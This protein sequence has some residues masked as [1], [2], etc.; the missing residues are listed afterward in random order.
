MKA[1]P[2]YVV[3]GAVS[4]LML[5]PLVWLIGATFKTNAEIFI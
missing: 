1:F 5:Y 3:L 2:R 4:I